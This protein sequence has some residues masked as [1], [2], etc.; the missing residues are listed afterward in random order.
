[1]SDQ[2]T[3]AALDQNHGKAGR[4][5]S[6]LAI[7][8]GAKFVESGHVG[9]II[10]EHEHLAVVDHDFVPAFC[11]AGEIT[12]D[13]PS[14]LLEGHARRSDKNCVRRIE[15]DQCVDIIGIESRRPAIEDRTYIIGRSCEGS[16]DDT[17]N[18]ART[19]TRRNLPIDPIRTSIGL[20]V[21][22]Q[23]PARS[24]GMGLDSAM[25]VRSALPSVESRKRS[26]RPVARAAR[27]DNV[28]PRWEV[29][30]ISVVDVEIPLEA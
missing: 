20:S 14:P 18:A 21:P 3:I 28:L 10:V 6:H 4:R 12:V 29:R 23:N 27:A 2:P 7:S 17:T 13:G 11:Q 15:I 25:L 22:R 16:T 8:M 30:P 26:K 5:F 19:S 9:N 1:M 24:E